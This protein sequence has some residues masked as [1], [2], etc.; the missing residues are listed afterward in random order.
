[1]WVTTGQPIRALAERCGYLSTIEEAGAYVV[2]DTCLVHC[3]LKEFRDAK[4]Y[5][6]MATNSP[7]M[8][9]YGWNVGGIPTGVYS[10][11]ECIEIAL[12]DRV[13]TEGGA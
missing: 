2:A 11:K 8:A 5:K 6:A 3:L 12:S 4:G 7:K 13:Y 1:V 9:H 10:V